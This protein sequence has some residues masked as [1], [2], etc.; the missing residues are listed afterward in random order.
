MVSLSL[1]LKYIESSTILNLISMGFIFGLPQ[2]FQQSQLM[3][4]TMGTDVQLTINVKAKVFSSLSKRV[5]YFLYLMYFLQS[6]LES[7][8]SQ[9]RLYYFYSIHT[10]CQA[11]ALLLLVIGHHTCH[12]FA[13]NL[14]FFNNAPFVLSSCALFAPGF[15]Y[16][17]ILY[18]SLIG[19][20][21]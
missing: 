19:S 8:I 12:S 4:I 6:L 10:S 18:T 11:L 5:V 7:F 17:T 21:T 13:F 20:C 1:S 14:N 15:W 9:R 2:N 16:P 3:S